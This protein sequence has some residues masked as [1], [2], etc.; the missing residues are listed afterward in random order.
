MT[1]KRGDIGV[2]GLAKARFFHPGQNIRDKWPNQHQTIH[3]SGVV[4]VRKGSHCVNRK[5]QLCYECRIAEIDD[6]TIFHIVCNNFKVDVAASIPFEDKA[7]VSVTVT[8][9]TSQ[10][11]ERERVTA[12][13]TAGDNVLPNIRGALAQEVAE[14]RQQGIE[15]DDDNKPAPKN[16]QPYVPATA[17]VGQ[18]VTLTI[19]P[20]RADPNCNNNKGSWKNMSWKK[21]KKMDGLTLFRMCFGCPHNL[22]PTMRLRGV[23]IPYPNL[24]CTWDATSSWLAL[25]VS[26]TGDCG[27]HQSQLLL[28]KEPPSSSRNTSPSVAS[29]QKRA[30]FDKQI[31][32]LPPSSASTM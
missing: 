2:K 11:S 6:N 30:Q 26:P 3:L 15:V 8:A 22:P 9:P 32:F 1:K 29:M 18:W 7:V 4:R 5:D 12:L 13:R 27:D 19:F 24:M 20:G 10:D 14:L 21:I 16:A 17:T 23:R 25:R 31:S 28:R